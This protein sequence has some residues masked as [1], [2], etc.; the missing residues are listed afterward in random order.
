MNRAATLSLLALLV[1]ARSLAFTFTEHIWLP[2]DFPLAYWVADDGTPESACEETLELPGACV[3]MADWGYDQWE[4]VSCAEITSVNMGLC[5][6]TGYNLGDLENHITF[7]DPDEQIS[8]SGTL[9]V[10]FT[11]SL[12]VAKIVDGVSF[13]HATDSD[14]VFNE[15]VV[16]DTHEDVASGADNGGVDINGVGTHEIGHTLGL[17]HSCQE[18]ETC[19]D[20]LLLEATMYWSAGAGDPE[21]ATI[22]SDDIDGITALYGPYATFTCSHELDDNL[23]IG[24]VPMNLKCIVESETLSEV[25]SAD[26]SFG[27]GGTASDLA[28][29]HEYTVPGNYTIQMTVHGNREACGVD[30]WEY[31]YRKVGYVRACGYPIPAFQ[32]EHVE[33]LEY[34]MLNDTDVSVYG[35]MQDIQ[36]T[37]HEGAGTSGPIVVDAV[38]AWEPLFELPA[39]GTYTIVLNVGGYAGTSAASLVIEATTRGGTKSTC[40]NGSAGGSAWLG[41]IMGLALLHR[42]RQ[43]D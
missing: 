22:A 5:E 34:R 39:A 17:D 35:C 21:P 4:S 31:E 32:A 24:V 9:A 7:N 42:R 33:G 30:G 10:T 14:I 2:E 19:T 38:K 18:D 43:D 41:M 37:V 27:D 1:P 8:E 25:D 16:F 23:A 20:P 15:D 26:W 11:Q 28:P 29:V 12:I 13:R 36:W 3:A 40:D 6:N